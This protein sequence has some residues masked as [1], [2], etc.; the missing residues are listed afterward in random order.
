MNKKKDKNNRRIV[1]V[2]LVIVIIAMGLFIY[3][4]V[5]QILSDRKTESLGL[6]Y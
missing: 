5:N 6:T 2:L 1:D 3:Y 4:R